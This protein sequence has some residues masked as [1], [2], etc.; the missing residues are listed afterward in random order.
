MA[1]EL[2]FESLLADL[3]RILELSPDDFAKAARLM[4][5]LDSDLE[6]LLEAARI[7]E[8]H[9]KGLFKTV[10]L[11]RSSAAKLFQS[12]GNAKG[13]GQFREDWR[14]FARNDFLELKE[15]LMA[16]RELLVENADFFRIACLR[17][18]IGELA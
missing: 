5:K 7:D 1:S 8:G 17:E 15:D 16:L 12:L 14:R 6:R 13:G 3:D 4:R 10:A 9:R 11:V 18:R 2:K